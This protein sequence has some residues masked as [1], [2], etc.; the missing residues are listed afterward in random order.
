MFIW[1]LLLINVNLTLHLIHD[2]LK[3]RCLDLY[4]PH[5]TSTEVK[6]SYLYINR[7]GIEWLTFEALKELA[8]EGVSLLG[9]ELVKIK[10][11]GL[12]HIIPNYLKTEFR[13]IMYNLDC[14]ALKSSDYKKEWWLIL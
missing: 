12:I 1:G 11:G 10:L 13:F 8:P 6:A 4:S 9:N 7:K 14:G 2:Y 3:L 5:V